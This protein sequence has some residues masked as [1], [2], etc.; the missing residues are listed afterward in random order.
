MTPEGLQLRRQSSNTVGTFRPKLQ[1]VYGYLRDGGI[2]T[3][4]AAIQPD[5]RRSRKPGGRDGCRSR[6]TS[7]ATDLYAAWPITQT[8]TV[9]GNVTVNVELFR[10]PRLNLGDR[11]GRLHQVTL[12]VHAGE[13]RITRRRAVSGERR[14][15]IRRRRVRI[16]RR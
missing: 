11:R 4:P 10:I 2:S 9:T 8:V 13:L 14:S 7:A 3:C 12:V 15:T 16:F 5:L 1:R 6:D